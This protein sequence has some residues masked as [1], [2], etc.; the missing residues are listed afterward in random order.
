M[1]DAVRDV[2]YASGRADSVV[3][4][5]VTTEDTKLHGSCSTNFQAINA[6]FAEDSMKKEDSPFLRVFILCDLCVQN[7]L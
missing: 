2:K 7:R 4:E 6:E 3:Q 5:R 1:L